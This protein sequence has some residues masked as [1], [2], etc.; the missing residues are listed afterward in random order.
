VSGA[1]LKQRVG[2]LSPK[3]ISCGLSKTRGQAVFNLK[4]ILVVWDWLA[5][6]FDLNIGLFEMIWQA[7]LA[8]NVSRTRTALMTELFRNCH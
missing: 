4:L 5:Q 2:S 7:C 6:S 8:E 3:L 1:K